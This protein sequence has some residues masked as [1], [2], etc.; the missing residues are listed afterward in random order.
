MLEFTI[1]YPVNQIITSQGKKSFA[2]TTQ[3]M[4]SGFMCY[5]T[6][7]GTLRRQ[8]HSRSNCLAS[9]NTVLSLPHA[10]AI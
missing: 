4:K 7:K 5:L 10:A 9:C 1:K 3:H 8:G 2:R 6:M